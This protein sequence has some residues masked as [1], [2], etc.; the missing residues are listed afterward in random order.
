M[1]SL[2]RTVRPAAVARFSRACASTHTGQHYAESD[3]R[4]AR[5]LGGKKK[6]VNPNFAI[7]M[8][9]AEPIEMTGK[10]HT[11]CDGGHGAL[12]HPKVFINLDKGIIKSCGYC[13]KQFKA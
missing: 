12:G 5:Y 13:G 1:F 2:A 11:W 3:P 9:A 4:N 6:E 10:T 7:D 8:V